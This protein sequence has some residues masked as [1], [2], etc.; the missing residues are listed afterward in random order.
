MPIPKKQIPAFAR[1]CRADWLAATTKLREEEIIRLKMWNGGTGQWREEEVTK[2]RGQGRPYLSENRMKPAV[3]QV[4]G[5]IRS[6]P[7]GPKVLPVGGGADGDTAAIHAGLIRECEH[8]CNAQQAYIVAGRYLGASGYGVIELATEYQDDMGMAQQVCINPCEDPAQWFFDH[9]ARRVDRKD[10]MWAGKVRSYGK[11]AYEAEFGKRGVRSSKS[12]IQ[13]E[14]F[15]T[16]YFR[17]DKFD[18]VLSDWV[19]PNGNGDYIVCE[20][21][22]VDKEKK[23]LWTHSDNVNRL[24]PIGKTAKLPKLKLRGT[25][26]KQFTHQVTKGELLRIVPTSKITKYL[27]DA[28]EVL[29]E[30][31]WLGTIIPGV[32]VLGQEIWIDG[33]LY[34]KSLISEAMDSQRL[35]NYAVTTGAE[36]LGLMPKAP[37]VGYAGQFDDERWETAHTETWAYLPVT[38]TFATPEGGDVANSELLPPPTRV[39]YRGALSETLPMAQYAGQAIE[40]ETSIFADRLGAAKGDKSGRAINALQS[41]SS[42]GTFYIADSLHHAIQSVYEQIIIINQQIRTEREVVT[43]V[44]PDSQHELATINTEFP[45]KIDPA[46]QKQAKARWLSQGRYAVVVTVGPDP[47]TLK[48]Q[49][50]L[51]LV[52]FLK[53]DP[54]IMAVPGV[55]AKALRSVSQGDPEIEAI[56]DL[57]EPQSAQSPQQLAQQLQ[58]VMSENAALKIIATKLQQEKDAK[59]PQVQADERKSIRDNL[60]RLEVAKITAS[61]DADTAEADREAALLEAG[62]GMAHDVALSKMEHGQTMEQ[63]AQQHAQALQQGDQQTANTMLTN[64]QSADLAPE[65]ETAGE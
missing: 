15:Q 13:A 64:Q 32:P 6:N 49:T 57:L 42:T 61:K 10:A 34:R 44:R 18:S 7:P 45:D 29:D 37:W 63:S 43:I 53:I 17:Q 41:Q 38:P 47:Q 14:E 54:Q 58:K 35:L 19:G 56:A 62:L 50:A 24:H 26:G 40:L 46:S 27:V 39:D 55:A 21:Y 9:N 30:T 8:R 59:L 28:Y 25:D 4:E 48:E 3:D 2:R 12:R 11:E 52:D 1:K 51:I 22:M 65:P 60:T 31:E 16:N 33:V 5:D 36:I 20:F 23:E